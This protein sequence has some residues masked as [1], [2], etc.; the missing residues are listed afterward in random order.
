LQK[1]WL[2]IGDTSRK[3]AAAEKAGYK[4]T[5]STGAKLTN[6]TIN[7]H[8]CRYIEKLRSIELKKYERDKLRHYKKYEEMREKA[9]EKNQFSPAINAEYRIGQAAGF[10][11]DRK[12][13]TTNS[14]EGLTREQLENRLQ[15]LERKMADTK[16]IIEA[17]I[18]EENKV[19][20][21]L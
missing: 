16:P 4:V 13:I 2:P 15:E 1:S 19:T 3:Q 21:L 7:P 11:I 10:Y 6:E 8:I 12:E 18:I 20:D 9:M 17:T 5:N 14:L